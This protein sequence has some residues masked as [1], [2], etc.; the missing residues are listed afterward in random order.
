MKYLSTPS[1]LNAIFVIS[2]FTFLFSNTDPAQSHADCE[3]YARYTALQFRTSVDEKCNFSG[4]LWE[5][6]IEEHKIWCKDVVYE[7]VR[8]VLKERQQMLLECR[9][10]ATRK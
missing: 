8:N 10:S 5:G 4:K 9:Q 1:F 2:G 7:Q 3:I 6:S